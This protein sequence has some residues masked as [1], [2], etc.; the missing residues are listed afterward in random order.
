MAR[1]FELPV[2]SAEITV[3]PDYAECLICGSIGRVR[4]PTT[5]RAQA[6]MIIR[7]LHHHCYR[8]TSYVYLCDGFSECMA[9]HRQIVHPI[10]CRVGG[11]DHNGCDQP[12]L[13]QRLV[14]STLRDSREWQ[15]G[16]YCGDHLR[17]ALEQ[18]VSGNKRWAKLPESAGYGME[19]G[20]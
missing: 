4:H 11:H 1:K 7:C 8:D 17:E 14:G 2:E 18:I 5:L 10:Q 3:T 6:G 15:K 20:P 12:V 19:M 9:A 16:F 13:S